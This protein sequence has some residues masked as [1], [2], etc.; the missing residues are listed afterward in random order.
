ML[1]DQIQALFSSVI[2]FIILTQHNP[3]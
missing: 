3:L 2:C 1:S